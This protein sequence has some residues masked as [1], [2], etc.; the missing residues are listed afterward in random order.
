MS[1]DNCAITKYKLGLIMEINNLVILGGHSVLLETNYD[2]WVIYYGPLLT[3]TKSYKV[4][5]KSTI[6]DQ[7]IKGPDS[8]VLGLK[9]VILIIIY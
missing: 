1:F 6:L 9:L 8:R 4:T 3:M 5:H 2:L 7:I